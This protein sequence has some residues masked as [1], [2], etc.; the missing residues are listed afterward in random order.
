MIGFPLA[1]ITN[2]RAK[3]ANILIA[4]FCAT[5]YYLL[6]LGCEALA[7]QK[8]IMPAISMWIPNVVGFFAAIYL[9]WKVFRT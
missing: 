7:S 1:V 2:K 4:I 3:S 5:G 9:N 6:F 8:I